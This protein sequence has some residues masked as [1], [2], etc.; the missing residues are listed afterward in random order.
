MAVELRNVLVRSGG[1]PLPTTILF[2]YPTLDALSS[3]LGRIW[4]LGDCGAPAVKP[5]VKRLAPP[6]APDI[7][8][9]SEEDAEALLN[10]ELAL[11]TARE[12]T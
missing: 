6:V 4:G 11:A 2:D 3:C 8:D 12:H 10:A 1:V 5:A 9:L 7:A